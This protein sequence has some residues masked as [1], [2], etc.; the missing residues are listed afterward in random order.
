MSA[1][2]FSRLGDYQIINTPGE[3]YRC[4]LPPP[5]P[6]RLM[7][8]LEPMMTAL[9]RAGYAVGGLNGISSLL[10]NPELFLYMFVRKE[11]LV[12]SQIEGTQCSLSDILL[13]DSGDETEG[14][15]DD[16]REVSCYVDAMEYGLARMRDGFPLSLRL[17]REIH[18][19][20]L[21]QG[22]GA[23]KQPGEFRTSQNWIGGTRPGTAMYVPPPPERLMEFLGP[24]ELFLHAEEPMLPVLVRA[25]LVHVQFE[26]IHPFLDGNGRLGR[27][28]ITLLLCHAGVL[29]QPLLYLSL[30]LKQNR[31]QYYSLLQEVRERGN[32]EDWISFFLRG[33]RETAEQAVDTARRILALL[34]TDRRRVEETGQAA[35]STLRVFQILDRHPVTTIT[36]VA[37]KTGLSYPTVQSAFNRLERLRILTRSGTGKRNKRYAYKAYLD[38]LSE[39]TEPIRP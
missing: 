39:G 24:F 21:A 12:S 38:I 3:K 17:I 30:Y 11:A 14:S 18:G 13:D 33:V 20:L 15:F 5:L 6:P 10:P 16:V 4:Y 7:V 19:R 23:G 27:L 31:S 36:R 26:T 32:W 29:R 28:L 9:E 34:A 35:S 8:T 25:A 22:R 37:E 1:P 2:H